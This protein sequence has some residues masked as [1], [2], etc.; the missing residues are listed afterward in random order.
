MAVTPKGLSDEKAA[1][2]MVALREGRTLRVFG[3]RAPRLEAYF[4]IHPE[5]AQEARP[6]IEANA[7][8]A[9]ARK[10]STWR[11]RTK[12]LCLKGLHPMTGANVRIDPSRGRRACLA[13][14]YIARDNP[15]LIKPD[16]LATI[17]RAFEAGAS[18]GQICN[19]RPVGGGKI[20]RSLI[21]TTSHKFYQQRRIDPEFDKFVATHTADSSST[22]QKKRWHRV[23]THV[24]TNTA[25]SEANDY[26]EI[27]AMIPANLPDKDDIISRIFEDLLSGALR[28]EGVRSR[29]NSYIK[30]HN[31]MF[32]TQYRKFG[33]SPLV[34]LDEV[35]F[36]DGSMTRGDTVTRGF[37][38]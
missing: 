14:R 29:V 21:L 33:G 37:W 32:P 30:E 18:Y 31:R 8:A 4:K 12:D 1:R 15:P 26:R 20:D 25:R 7:K 19:G 24:R 5:Y 16:V 13:C 3:V 11:E 2:M 28:R 17:R 10:G 6:L 27:R 36:E 9:M 22:G 23:I 34:S 38:D 35:L